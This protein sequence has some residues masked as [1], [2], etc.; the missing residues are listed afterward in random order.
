MGQICLA[1]NESQIY[2][3]MFAKFVCGPT[4]VSEKGGG[5]VHTDRKTDRQTDRQT[6]KL[7]LYIVDV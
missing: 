2:P 1:E 3:N 6:G 4:L 5:G 7:Q